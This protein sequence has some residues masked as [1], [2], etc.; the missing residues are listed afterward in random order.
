MAGRLVNVVRLAAD[1]L[2]IFATHPIQLAEKL[3]VV[4]HAE[5]VMGLRMFRWN[6]TISCGFATSALFS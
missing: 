2:V 4:R 6:A 1:D 3:S 5:P